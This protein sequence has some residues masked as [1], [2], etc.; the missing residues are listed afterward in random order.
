MVPGPDPTTQ[1]LDGEERFRTTEDPAPGSAVHRQLGDDDRD[2]RPPSDGPVNRFAEP[3]LELA[4]VQKPGLRVPRGELCQSALPTVAGGD[5]AHGDELAA[6]AVPVVD[7]T[8]GGEDADAVASSMREGQLADRLASLLELGMPVDD[9][10]VVLRCPE[11]ER[12][13]GAEELLPLEA[14]KPT[15]LAVHGADPAVADEQEAVRE[16]REDR[17]G[18]VPFAVQRLD[19]PA[20]RG[21][22][23]PEGE[24]RGE[25]ERQSQGGCDPEARRRRR[26]ATKGH[27]GGDPCR[28]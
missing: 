12:L 20:A 15:E 16:R 13:R 28:S 5:V 10:V 21:P 23:E 11:R 7:D 25:R 19:H 27:E 9:L 22:A 6:R 8:P 4:P 1:V 17:A 2:V 26:R 18:C 24:Q 14:E 3:L